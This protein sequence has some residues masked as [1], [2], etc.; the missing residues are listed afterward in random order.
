MINLFAKRFLLFLISIALIP[1]CLPI[2]A[3]AEDAG[4][5]EIILKK[6][7]TY[8]AF[9]SKITRCIKLP[10]GYHEGLFL[11]GQN[12]WVNNGE[13]QNTWVIG[14]KEGNKVSEILPT[15][16]FTEGITKVS[17]EKY[18]MTDWETKKLY[19]IKIA[20][21]RMAPISEITLEPSHPAGIISN[22]RLLYVITW[23]RSALG[24][25][26]HLLEFDTDGK[27][28]R[29]IRI[30]YIEEPSQ[31]AWDGKY[32]WISSWFD[33]H[34][35]K[36]DIDKM[37]IEGFFRSLLKDTTG[38]AWDGKYFWVTGT[39]ADLYQFELLSLSAEAPSL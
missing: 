23:D 12:I 14:L 8:K 3:F 32:L 29:K 2:H 9:P 18:W 36:I 30:K 17:D 27:L 1:A 25:K 35:Y 38:I 31:I 5:K 10:E 7:K 20:S 21:N 39:K 6:S 13:S 22:G 19:N 26:Y 28:L 33:R 16:T 11:D 24:T 34:V 15:A 4:Q 37:E